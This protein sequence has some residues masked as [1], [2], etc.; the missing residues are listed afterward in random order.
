M[1]SKIRSDHGGQFKNGNFRIFCN[2]NGITMNFWLQ[3][4]H[5]VKIKNRSL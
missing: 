1:I 2:E 5:N 4:I 3:E